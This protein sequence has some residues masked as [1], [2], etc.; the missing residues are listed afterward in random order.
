M[1]KE[2]NFT[3]R[4]YLKP[5]TCMLNHEF[6]DQYVRKLIIDTICKNQETKPLIS[7]IVILTSKKS[8]TED[9]H[10]LHKTNIEIKI[11]TK[12]I[13]HR[14]TVMTYINQVWDLFSVFIK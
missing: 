6:Y 4:N 1:L 14:D 13:W 3:P 12:K 5:L 9:G 8:Q 2:P 10:D 7:Y 11:D